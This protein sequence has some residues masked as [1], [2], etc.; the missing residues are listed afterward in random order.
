MRR[1]N[2]NMTR[3]L[4]GL[5]GAVALTAFVTSQGAADVIV[6][7][8]FDYSDGVLNGN[9]GGADGTGA[10]TGAWSGD[11]NPSVVGG[12]VKSKNT[13]IHRTF[14]GVADG[15][16][17]YVGGTLS[18]PRDDNMGFTIELN[19][20]GNTGVGAYN[21]Q[22]FGFRDGQRSLLGNKTG[23]KGP[24]GTPLRFV[25]RVDLN[26]SGTQDRLTLWDDDIGDGS[27]DLT[28]S[29]SPRSVK[30][31]N[32][33]SGPLNTIGFQG[34][35]LGPTMT[36]DDLNVTTTFDEAANAAMP[37][38]GPPIPEPATMA[39]LGLGG[40]ALAARRRRRA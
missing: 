11:N 25:C 27:F 19:D 23:P 8:P 30:T 12:E 32:V 26:Y 5:M 14:S 33:F 21:M 17:V 15:T 29:D 34:Q 13:G 1:A 7:E 37:S 28:E 20:P 35:A 2:G 4:A 6:G 40:L 39:L 38:A 24:F 36:A 9:D 10:W 31:Q 22:G 18:M 3:L 16:T